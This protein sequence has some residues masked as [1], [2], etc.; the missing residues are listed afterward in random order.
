M[1]VLSLSLSLSLSPPL[2]SSASLDIDILTEED[3]EES[4]YAD[5]DSCKSVAGQ[6]HRK[7]DQAESEAGASGESDL[8][9][10]A[11]EVRR[12]KKEQQQQ[13]EQDGM[14]G[15][16]A[17]YDTGNSRVRKKKWG[18]NRKNDDYDDGLLLRRFNW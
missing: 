5:I 6:E 4:D 18:G 11:A 15:N 2:Y 7:C 16:P 3:V 17:V 9:V 14:W 13:R 12:M 8:Y 10:P 1:T